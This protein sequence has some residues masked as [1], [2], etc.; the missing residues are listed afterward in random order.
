MARDHLLR[1]VG[2]IKTISFA[3]ALTGRF[4][5]NVVNRAND[6]LAEAWAL[7]GMCPTVGLFFLPA[8][9][10]WDGERSSF[11]HAIH[12][13]RDHR[14][15]AMLVGVYDHEVDRHGYVRF[16]PV[17]RHVPN[18]G[19]PALSS[20]WSYDEL[21]SEILRLAGVEKST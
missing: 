2:S 5:K 14:F 10:C 11:A 20:T 9:A 21:V 16:S 19:L 13:L 17:E 6:L 8:E 1:L 4:T 12:T 3:D 18:R 15:T 7:Q